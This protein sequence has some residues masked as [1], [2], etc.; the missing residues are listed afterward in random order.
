MSSD[1]IR[2]YVAGLEQ[3]LKNT[4]LSLKEAA[5]RLQELSQLVS[6]ERFVP[7]SIILDIRRTYKEIQ[8]QLTKFNNIEQLL[9]GKYRL[10]YRRDPTRYRD[11]MEVA[12]VAKNCFFKV[13]SSLREAEAKR[14]W[15]EKMLKVG[16]R[17]VTAWFRSEE[18]ETALRSC[19]RLSESFIPRAL[20]NE[21]IGERRQGSVDRPR[22]L[23]LFLFS[24]E[25]DRISDLQAG[26]RIRAYDIRE[27]YDRDEFR[28]AL[29]HLRELSASEMEGVMRRLAGRAEFSGLKCLLLSVHSEN[30]L[31]KQSVMCAKAIV[32]QMEPG[33]VRVLRTA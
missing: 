17:A 18:H 3:I 28:G 33:E 16:G 30:D 1:Q 9:T 31:E 29:I 20:S 23:S 19:F 24:G 7:Q 21:E 14:R 5:A 8:E 4:H 10:Y 32:Q 2:A 13:E 6:P 12:H 25:E 11:V 15:R 26:I 27:R 22:S